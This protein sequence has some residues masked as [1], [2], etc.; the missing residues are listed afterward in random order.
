M[1][2]RHGGELEKEILIVRDLF[3]RGIII[4]INDDSQKMK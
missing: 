1:K 4:K 3:H 2:F